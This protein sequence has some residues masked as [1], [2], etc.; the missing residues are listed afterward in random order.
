[1]ICNNITVNENGILCFAGVSVEELAKK[2]GTPLYIMDE[3]KVRENCRTYQNAM[4]K[5]FGGNA[6]TIYASKACSFKKM[7]N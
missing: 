6:L 5:H 2:F 4:K 7:Y 3:N 1:M